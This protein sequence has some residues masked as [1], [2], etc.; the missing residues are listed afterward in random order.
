MTAGVAGYAGFGSRP[1]IMMDN[2]LDPDPAQNV[3]EI[4][5]LA[6]FGLAQV[7]VVA[8]ERAL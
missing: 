5:E 4:R 1:I 6:W 8:Q 7:L 3:W 2:G